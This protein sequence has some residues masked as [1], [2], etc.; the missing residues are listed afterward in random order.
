MDGAG[1]LPQSFLVQD[2]DPGGLDLD[3]WLP[4]AD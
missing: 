3:R 2:D 4:A 1:N